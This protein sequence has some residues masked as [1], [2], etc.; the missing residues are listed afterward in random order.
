MITMPIETPLT[1]YLH[2]KA[3]MKEIPLNGTFELTPCCNLSCKMCYVRMTRQEQ[4]RIAPLR[5]AGEWLDLAQR[6]KEAGM[7]Y[8]LLTGGEPFLRKD[9]REILTGLSRMGLIITINT[10]GTLIDEETVRWLKELPVFRVNITL[11]GASRETYGQLCGNPDAYDAVV[12]AIHLLKDA[13]M[14]VKLNC[15]VTPYNAH[16]LE[17]IFAFAKEEGLVVQAASYMFPPLRR[18][19]DMVGQN[20]RFEPEE[21]A[22]QQARIMYL[23]SGKEAFL[24]RMKEQAPL[25]LSE[26]FEDCSADVPKEGL[27][28]QCRAGRCSFWITWNGKMLP[29]GMLPSEGA[30][31]VFEEDYLKCWKQI[32]N[33]IDQVRMPSKCNGCELKEQCKAC[34]AMVYTETGRFDQIPE[35]RCVM[36]QKLGSAC[37]QLEYE[38]LNEKRDITNE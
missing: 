5:T 22:R 3:V 23:T 21:A 36:A 29:C 13:G 24:K 6:A 37:K 38:L 28:V 30:P 11:Y 9:L 19:K 31:N 8:L 27:G 4:E 20:D 12:R 34:A 1:E 10:N 33:K 7:M 35:Y 15:S 18:D 26:D 17:D 32:R 25:S 16:D 14:A 2:T